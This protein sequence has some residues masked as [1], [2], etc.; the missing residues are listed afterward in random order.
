MMGMA[1]AVQI[2][3]Q[4]GAALNQSAVDDLNGGVG[5]MS[6]PLHVTSCG[7]TNKTL[8]PKLL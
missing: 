3:K 7:G 8:S 1:E 2:T 6:A 5:V 4:E